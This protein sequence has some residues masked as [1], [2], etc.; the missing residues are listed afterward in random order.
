MNKIKTFFFANLVLLGFSVSTFAGSIIL[1][2][3]Q[4]NSTPV[5]SMFIILNTS[6]ETSDFIKV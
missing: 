6:A 5:Y 3:W 4:D 1:P 2:F